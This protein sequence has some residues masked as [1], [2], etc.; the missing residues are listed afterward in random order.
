MPQPI[1]TNEKAIQ[2]QILNKKMSFLQKKQYLYHVY[3]IRI[4]CF[5]SFCVIAE[6]G[7]RYFRSLK[8]KKKREDEGLYEEKKKQS[9]RNNRKKMVR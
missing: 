9:R 5:C 6:A 3:S 1:V 2:A 8:D 4:I 7:K